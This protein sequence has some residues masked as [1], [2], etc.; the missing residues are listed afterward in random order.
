MFKLFFVY[1]FVAF[2]IFWLASDTQVGASVYSMRDNFI[3]LEFPRESLRSA[4][5]PGPWYSFYWNADSARE[6][7]NKINDAVVKHK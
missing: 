4:D 3:L 7:L 6:E 5:D 2:I 1:P